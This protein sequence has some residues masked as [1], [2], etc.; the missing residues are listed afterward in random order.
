VSTLCLLAAC[1]GGGGGGG[2]PAPAAPDAPT[3]TLQSTEAGDTAGLTA[4]LAERTLMMAQLAGDEMRAQAARGGLVAGGLSCLGDGTLDVAVDDRDGSGGLGVGDRLHLQFNACRV[5]M[6]EGR[7][8]GALVIDVLASGLVPATDAWAGDLSTSGFAIQRDDMRTPARF[9]GS[10]HAESRMHLDGVVLQ[11][12]SLDDK[13][14]V[15]LRE[16]ASA[17]DSLSD[18]RLSKRLDYVNSRG[19]VDLIYTLDSG[20]LGGRVNVASGSDGLQSWIGRLPDTGV[21]RI[22]GKREVIVV[23]AK[24]NSGATSAD[25]GFDGDANGVT[26]SN[27]VREWSD[28][29]AGFLWWAQGLVTLPASGAAYPI[30][31]AGVPGLARYP[32]GAIDQLPLKPVLEWTFTINLDPARLPPLFVLERQAD[33]PALPFSRADDD[34]GSERVP[35][36]VTLNGARLTLAASEQLQPGRRYLLRMLRQGVN[37]PAEAVRLQG[38]RNDTIVLTDDDV[39]ATRQ[40]F[41]AA[42]RFTPIPATTPAFGD[43]VVDATASFDSTQAIASYAWRQTEGPA[44]VIDSASS[45]TTLIRV[46]GGTVASDAQAML[47]LTVTN[48]AGEKDIALLPVMLRAP[49]AQAQQLY[50]RSSPGSEIGNG[51]TRLLTAPDASFVVRRP[52]VGRLEF[53]VTEANGTHWIWRFASPDGQAPVPNTY[54][55]ADT[56]FRDT[57]QVRA[58]MPAASRTELREIA[59]GTGGELTKLAVDFFHDSRSLRGSVAGSVRFNSTLPVGP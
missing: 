16:D 35:L 22:N 39:F 25:V 12:E 18:L 56:D 40:S 51:E 28:I 58:P 33:L 34:W 9:S 49:T 32:I 36:Q 11:A 29:V 48:A 10:L 38:T 50:F 59:F 14:P 15:W 55:N 7:L 46:A 17:S 44:L 8:S 41:T 57:A 24:M 3:A 37:G 52:A 31:P 5:P 43:L 6:F 13:P 42:A 27:A 23:R 2:T 20:E 30:P 19:R 53:E 47:E 45:S 1:G 4:W 54:D 21:L 26:E